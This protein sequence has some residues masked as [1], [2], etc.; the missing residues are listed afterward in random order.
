M[1]VGNT[2]PLSDKDACAR[3]IY[4]MQKLGVNT[5]PPMAAILTYNEGYEFIPSTPR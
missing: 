5:Y 4:L 3:D 1:G 2:D